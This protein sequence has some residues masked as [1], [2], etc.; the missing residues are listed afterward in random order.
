MK[1]YVCELFSCPS[2][3][4]RGPFKRKFK[5]PSPYLQ[6]KLNQIVSCRAEKFPDVVGLLNILLISSGNWLTACL[7]DDFN[8]HPPWDKNEEGVKKI[9]VQRKLL[10]RSL[11]KDKGLYIHM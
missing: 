3:N 9:H 4:M 8:G 11:R 6:K 2:E 1:S 7:L 10:I 5:F